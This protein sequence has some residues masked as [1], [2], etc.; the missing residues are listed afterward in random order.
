MSDTEPNLESESERASEI[1]RDQTLL[2]VNLRDEH[3]SLDGRIG[4]LGSPG[5]IVCYEFPIYCTVPYKL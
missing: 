2:A 1:S 3:S 4:R 5:P